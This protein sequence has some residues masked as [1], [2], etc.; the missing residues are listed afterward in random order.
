MYYYQGGFYDPDIH[1]E[2]PASAIAISAAD[3]ER[4]LAGQAAGQVIVST[5]AGPV[6][7]E[8]T[9]TPAD[10][11]AAIVAAIVAATQDRLDAFAR[12]RGY[13]GILSACTYAHGTDPVFGYE[14]DYCVAVRDATWRTLYDILA[15][16]ETGTRPAPADYAE[17][18]PELPALD[19]PP[20]T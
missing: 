6:L 9:P 7:A 4:L 19:W 10:V 15:A 5:P 2:I 17:I 13:D 16:V 1:P 18:E 12:T 11:R 20:T 8:R 14:G 3:H